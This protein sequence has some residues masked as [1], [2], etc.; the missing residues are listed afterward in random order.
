[1]FER[2]LAPVLDLANSRY[3]AATDDLEEA[4][5]TWK[6]A[7]GSNSIGFLIRH[8]SEVDYRFCAMYF[9]S[10]LPDHVELATIGPVRDEGHFTKLAPLLAFRKEAAQYL[11]QCLRQLPEA[12]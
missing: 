3:D 1:M 12:A 4:Q 2:T 11:R 8:I 6:L 9:H 5:L 7:P 10:A